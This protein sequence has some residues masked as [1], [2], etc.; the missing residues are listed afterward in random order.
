[1]DRRILAAALAAALVACTENRSSVEVLG[2]AAPDNIPSC[3]FKAGGDFQLGPGV[4]DLA[5]PRTYATVVYVNNHLLDPSQ[6]TTGTVIA[7][8][9]WRALAAHIRVNPSDYLSKFPPNPAL[10]PLQAE[11]RLPLD[12]QTLPPG[13]SGAQFVD[14]ISS[15]MGTAIAGAGA[16]GEVVVGIRLEGETLDG[17]AL[18][19]GEWF[20]PI[21]VCTGCIGACPVGQTRVGCFGSFQDPVVCQ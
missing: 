4:L 1:M 10:L 16:A 14:V 8:K 20:F 11:D 13:E 17:A 18:D 21:D 15:T 12:G 7:A 5:G 9:S 6:V 2:R 3:K 19:T